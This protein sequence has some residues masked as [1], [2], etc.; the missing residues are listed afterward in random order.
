MP[1][2]V[3]PSRCL[4]VFTLVFMLLAGCLPA[5][6]VA[7]TIEL[8]YSHSNGLISDTRLYVDLS[9]FD[10][11]SSTWHGR[12]FLPTAWV[13]TEIEGPIA[14]RRSVTQPYAE[15]D[16][17]TGPLQVTMTAERW[18][19]AAGPF[20]V[21]S[22]R[23][24]PTVAHSYDHREEGDQVSA[25]GRGRLEFTV[26]KALGVS[27]N[28]RLESEFLLDEVMGVPGTEREVVGGCCSYVTITTSAV[29]APSV[30]TLLLAG[31][32]AGLVRWRRRHR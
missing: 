8:D 27:R 18:L 28:V 26:A 3:T 21:L 15:S 19:G 16:Y 23:L 29:P 32:T 7:G 13:W 4:A 14:R 30:A 22:G 24:R 25:K 1:G 6:A 20:P 31:V 12:E 9:W 2:D 17:F 10:I 11:D 5:R